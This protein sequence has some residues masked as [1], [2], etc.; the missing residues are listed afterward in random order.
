[1]A[2][3]LKLERQNLK[4][5]G[6]RLRPSYAVAVL[7]VGLFISHVGFRTYELVTAPRATGISDQ[8]PKPMLDSTRQQNPHFWSLFEEAP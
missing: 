6:G 2:W 5:E 4:A 3:F 8:S 7:L 1:M